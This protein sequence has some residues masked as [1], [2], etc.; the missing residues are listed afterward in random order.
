MAAEIHIDDEP[1]L[2]ATVKDQDGTV[3]NIAA[4]TGM[5]IIIKKPSAVSV[6][7]TAILTTDGLDGKMEYQTVANELDETGEW[8]RQGKVVLAGKPFSSDLFL[9][10]VEANL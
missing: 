9:F 8:Q 6:A 3:V 4:A 1:I 7:R 10:P 5:Q 2:R